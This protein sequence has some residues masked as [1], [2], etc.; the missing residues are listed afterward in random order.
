MYVGQAD[1]SQ[2]F[3]LASVWLLILGFG[4]SACLLPII[5]TVAQAY[6]DAF[7]S[8]VSYINQG[9]TIE[10]LAP[11]NTML[12]ML[13][14]SVVGY[15][16]A[17]ASGNEIYSFRKSSYSDDKVHSPKKTCV[18]PS[19]S[20][21]FSY[22]FNL[23]LWLPYISCS[24]MCDAKTNELMNFGLP[25][26]PSSNLSRVKITIMSSRQHKGKNIVNREILKIYSIL[27]VTRIFAAYL[28]T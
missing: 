18:L 11:I 28:R 25:C 15:P 16:I 14:G 1:P 23:R 20:Y 27:H 13:F 5:Y 21:L 10:L 17:S 8:G 12:F 9:S 2:V 26:L 6:Q 7:S 24:C 19:R 22:S 4:S 3:A